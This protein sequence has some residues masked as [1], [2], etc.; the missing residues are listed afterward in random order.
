MVFRRGWWMV[1]DGLNP[2]VDGI[3]FSDIRLF[4]IEYP[5][6]YRLEPLPREGFYVLRDGRIAAY[7]ERR[8]EVDDG[9]RISHRLLTFESVDDFEPILFPSPIDLMELRGFVGSLRKEV[10]RVEGG[11]WFGMGDMEMEVE[12]DEEK[13][14]GDEELVW[15]TYL[16]AR[17]KRAPEKIEKYFRSSFDEGSSIAELSPL[18]V[19]G[20]FGSVPIAGLPWYAA[21]FGRDLAVFGLQ[22]L[23]IDPGMVRKI[24]KTL[25]H[26]QGKAVEPEKE[27]E[28]G[29]VIHEF[30]FG[31]SAIEYYG[32]VDATPLYLILAAEYH[33]KTGDLEF[34]ESMKDSLKLALRWMMDY[35]DVDRDGLIE[36]ETGGWLRNKGWKDSDEAVVF[37]DGR[38]AEG[39]IALIEVQSYAH[40]AYSEMAEVLERMGEIHLAEESWKKAEILRESVRKFRIGDYFAMALDGRKERVDSVTSNP[41]NALFGGVFDSCSASLIADRMAEEDLLTP[42]GLRTMSSRMKAFHPVSY[43]NGS[44]W[45]HDNWFAVMGLL[46]YGERDLAREI[47]RR[48]MRASEKLGGLPEL[49]VYIDGLEDPLPYPGACDP[50]LWSIGSRLA[51]EKLSEEVGL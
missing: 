19:P 40:L 3:F 41:A 47:V 39:P 45:P 38:V 7:L 2:K 48:M 22:I 9:L 23:E 29:K 4:G 13:A 10:R 36:Y 11:Y 21:L 28:P 14:F 49:F 18:L 5:E 26:F 17:I 1:I 37:E 8:F 34:L 24:L 31:P 46:R 12:I 33:R 16:K 15:N 27:E 25:E 51:F 42:Y 50:Q 43:H 35:G 20:P 6:G 44:I 30:R 32:T